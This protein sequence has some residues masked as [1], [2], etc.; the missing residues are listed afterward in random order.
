MR[1][2]AEVGGKESV[3]DDSKTQI[4]GTVLIPL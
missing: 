4:R 2:A 3:V 1:V